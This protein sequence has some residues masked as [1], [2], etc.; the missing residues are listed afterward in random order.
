MVRKRYSPRHA[1][2]KRSKKPFVFLL[3]LCIASLLFFRDRVACHL[4]DLYITTLLPKEVR[5]HLVIEK[6]EKSNGHLYLKGITYTAEGMQ[7]KIDQVDVY[8][9]VHLLP[10]RMV[11][12]VNVEAPAFTLDAA[13]AGKADASFVALLFPHRNLEV[14]LHVEKGSI[15]LSETPGKPLYF[16]FE[17][18]IASCDVGEFHLADAKEAESKDLGKV[19][20]WHAEEALH[21]QFEAEVED[22]TVLTPLVRNLRLKEGSYIE[23]LEGKLKGKADLAIHKAGLVHKLNV[24]IDLQH[25]ALES[26][27]KECL[28]KIDTCAGHFS[29]PPE[30]V[31]DAQLSKD[32]K[33]PFWKKAEGYLSF[34]GGESSHLY[35]KGLGIKQAEGEVLLCPT[36]DPS[37]KLTA[38]L[39][40]AEKQMPLELH[41]SGVLHEDGSFWLQSDLSLLSAPQTKAQLVIS[42]C[43][44]G[45]ST[46][47]VQT[48]CQ[49]ID[50]EVVSF[51]SA[52]GL[53]SANIEMNAG[54]IDGLAT[55]F[56]QN[57][58]LQ[59]FQ[60]DRVVGKGARFSLPM[61][62][63]YV[64]VDK[65]SSQG[66]L[67]KEGEGWRLK[68]MDVDVESGT[69]Q[70]K[71]LKL[72]DANLSLHIH[73]HIIEP[74]TLAA[75]WES[76]QIVMSA[77][78]TKDALQTTMEIN[79]SWKSFLR[80]VSPELTI[81]EDVNIN[82]KIDGTLNNA[83]FSLKGETQFLSST[84]E[85]DPLTFAVEM[86]LSGKGAIWQKRCAF[87]DVKAHVVSHHLSSSVYHPLLTLMGNEVNMSGNIALD[88]RLSHAKI[89]GTLRSED[90]FFAKDSMGLSTGPILEKPAHFSFDCKTKELFAEADLKEAY[91]AEESSKIALS[92]ISGSFAWQDHRLKAEKIHAFCEG[93]F[94][95]FSLFVDEEG[96]F[97]EIAPLEGKIENLCKIDFLQE[98]LGTTAHKIQGTFALPAGGCNILIQ[99]GESQWIWHWKIAASLKEMSCDL[100]EHVKLQQVECDLSYDSSTMLSSLKKM[101]GMLKAWQGTYAI[102]FSDFLFDPRKENAFDLKV[103]DAKSILLSLSGSVKLSQDVELSFTKEKTSLLA[104]PLSIT[105]CKIGKDLCVKQME[106]ECTLSDKRLQE[107]FAKVVAAGAVGIDEAVKIEEALQSIH[108][109]ALAQAIYSREENWKFHLE[110]T[111]LA[112]KDT[113]I[114][115]CELSAS[116]NNSL[117]TIEK[118][119]WNSSY[120]QAAL[121]VKDDLLKLSYLKFVGADI[122]LE[123]EASL[124][125]KSMVLSVPRMNYSLETSALGKDLSKY[126]KGTFY[127]LAAGSCSFDNA[128]QPVKLNGRASLQSKMQYPLNADIKNRSEIS[129]SY[130]VIG[131][132][133]VRGFDV[134][135]TAAGS[136]EMLAR[137]A[138]SELSYPSSKENIALS[139]CLLQLAPAGSD[140]L[141]ATGLVP[142]DLCTFKK[143]R[144]WQ[145]AGDV[146]ITKHGVEAL[147]HLKAGVYVAGGKEYSLM[148]PRV[149]LSSSSLHL[150]AKMQMGET[151]VFCDVQKE[152][153]KN[154]PLYLLIRSSLEAEGLK[155]L[156]VEKNGSFDPQRIE[157]K[158][159]GLEANLQKSSHITDGSFFG[160]VKINFQE[161][162][163]LLSSQIKE[164]VRGLKLGPGYTMQGHFFLPESE[165]DEFSFQG[166]I[167]AEDGQLLG[168]TFRSLQ[169]KANITGAKVVLEDVRIDDPAGQLSIK[170]CEIDKDPYAN[171]WTLSMPLGHIREFRP[172]LLRENGKRGAEKPFLL[173]NLSV[174]DLQGTLGDTKSFTGNGALHF[175]NSSK[176]EFSFL[177]IPFEMFKDLGLDTGIL[178]PIC[179][180]AD[181]SIAKG[182]CLFHELKNSYSEGRR[183]EFYLSH[184]IPEYIDLEGNWHIDL[185]MKQH[186][187][188]KWS[189]SLIVS[190]RGKLDKPKYSLKNV[191]DLL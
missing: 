186:V 147:L 180:E 115:R 187:L 25:F 13:G 93:I 142:R 58:E 42:L 166:S 61:H 1:K 29:Y 145:M 37:L 20:L 7:V 146:M 22:L 110:G 101:K 10:F 114:S 91:F 190:I 35:K 134:T 47:V 55:A 14:K 163:P 169:L 45:A 161:A 157:G 188:L 77:C 75:T 108:G 86:P 27:D 69:F 24:E 44:T 57:K 99:K 185:R 143:D 141:S 113:P 126:M 117:W 28:Y 95:P 5:S 12:Y 38:A 26:H 89:K 21:A 23:H 72:T 109:E 80:M 84:G 111:G 82:A 2:K 79:S 173:K 56:I 112:W 118:L 155:I 59:K 105:R 148:E 174:Y 137:L 177:D 73:D 67:V 54:R 64:G 4:L 30:A 172:S 90:L 139:Q 175:L 179:G 133:K 52:A 159:L 78:G 144:D 151:P 96:V 164:V 128:L 43:R 71:E 63:A 48:D 3:F 120:L 102:V 34:T 9:A 6:R 167:K 19:H 104:I 119:S 88:M 162:Q 50:P 127:G 122:K 94:I 136:Q 16:S 106:M 51:V 76:G 149:Q 138:F 116:Y 100:S 184:D 125:R 74:S 158:L 11:S 53:L 132:L 65:I 68:E 92:Q 81:K 124:D 183:S 60:W 171:R 178:T 66:L 170:T 130:D 17:P 121:S 123:L 181:F 154:S 36:Q 150:R 176:K 39:T 87:T 129:F 83:L 140:A 33:I 168:F 160:F 135:A 49:G 107:S 191:E 41:S 189:E 62:A 46:Y 98:Y 32:P 8:S 18:G 103:N 15:E 97:I 131:G 40:H 70:Q 182:R 153:V 156:C 85:R 165:S 152:F 31:E